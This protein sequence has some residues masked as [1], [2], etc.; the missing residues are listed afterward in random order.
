[1]VEIHTNSYGFHSP[2]NTISGC[3][4][5]ILNIISRYLLIINNI[6]S[7]N[8]NLSRHLVYKW[9]GA[10][11]RKPCKGDEPFNYNNRQIKKFRV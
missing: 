1:M 5:N 6:A 9:R 4:L 8:C 10:K 7:I 11:T 2:L 3:L